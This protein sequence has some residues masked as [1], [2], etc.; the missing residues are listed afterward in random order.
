MLDKQQLIDKFNAGTLSSEE[1]DVLE[2]MFINNQ[3]E[4]NSFSVFNNFE[5]Y[6]DGQG[7][8]FSMDHKFQEML[9]NEMQELKTKELK[10]N[11]FSFLPLPIKLAIPTM[12]LVCGFF[13]GKS[14]DTT[15][16]HHY[17]NTSDNIVQPNI[18][19]M[20]KLLNHPSSSERMTLVNNANKNSEN[21]QSTIQILFMSLN[22]DRSSS[23]RMAAVDALMLHADDATV[24]E[25]L[26]KSLSQQ[27]SLLMIQYITEA[28][29]I[30]GENIS[31]DK[32]E[33]IINQTLPNEGF[34]NNEQKIY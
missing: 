3:V 1:S 23:V 15:S 31:Q 33:Y 4:I 21:K 13:I 24:R 12:L 11:W 19:M 29:K 5:K 9:S 7:A 16:N 26:I 25:G 6:V 8:P 27:K 28:L 18:E 32:M 17:A 14:W 34:L 2:E 10:R 20:N 22:H 30:I